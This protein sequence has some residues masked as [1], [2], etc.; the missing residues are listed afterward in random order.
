MNCASCHQPIPQERLEALPGTTRCVKC[1]DTRK[2]KG[3]LIFE[4]KTGGSLQVVS[5]EQQ[6]RMRAAEDSIEGRVSRL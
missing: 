2:V 6:Q 3:A 5:E 4:H 1:S